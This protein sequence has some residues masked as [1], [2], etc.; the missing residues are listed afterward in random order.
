MDKRQRSDK[1]D[2]L[3]SKTQSILKHYSCPES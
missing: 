2:W 3:I 1:Y